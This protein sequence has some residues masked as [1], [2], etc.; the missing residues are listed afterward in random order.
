M[1]IS[2]EIRPAGGRAYALKELLPEGLE[3]GTYGEGYVLRDAENES[4][5]IV[6]DPGCIGSGICLEQKDGAITL[7]LA[8]ITGAQEIRSF[9]ALAA[10]ICSACGASV[11]SRN[12]AIASPG[13][14]DKY[15]KEDIENTEKS[16]FV[17]LKKL[18][19]G[20]AKTVTLCGA[21]NPVAL[22][23]SDL[24]KLGADAE[25]LG[26][27]LHAKQSMKAWYA[28]PKIFEDPESGS[29]VGVFSLA[30]DILTV[31]PEVP[32]APFYLERQ[33]DVWAAYLYISD[34]EYGYVPYQE[35]AKRCAKLGTYDALHFLTKLSADQMRG[36]IKKFP[37]EM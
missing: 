7:D 30:P 6:F 3:Y 15:I 17:M 28:V 31:L 20:E 37:L 1:G 2:I 26:E 35:L 13:Q 19:S 12:D 21:L 5:V 34:D 4:S 23:L 9:Y 14:A 36:F 18:E 33:V 16:L 24:R 22:D 8:L 29:L 11:Y 27:L 32:Q 25:R 10:H